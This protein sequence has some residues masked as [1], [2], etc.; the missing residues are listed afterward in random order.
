[1]TGLGLYAL[2]KIN[3]DDLI[4]YSLNP[5]TAKFPAKVTEFYTLA[6]R[7]GNKDI[8]YLKQNFGLNP[9]LSDPAIPKEKAI[10]YIT[11]FIDKGFDINTLSN[12][13]GL[14]ILHCAIMDNDSEVVLFL[15]VK[16]ADAG[17]K[18][19]Y[20][21]IEGKDEK[22]TLFG[23]NSMEL[24]KHLSKKDQKDRTNII[25]MLNELNIRFMQIP[26]GRNHIRHFILKQKDN[27]WLS[28]EV[29]SFSTL[30]RVFLTWPEKNPDDPLRKRCG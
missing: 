14:T 4:R 28:E 12:S 17:I 15:L 30:N 27:T 1:M 23:M 5:E 11:F 26:S 24:A 22:T 13:S 25:L 29:A 9:L 2:S 19:G 16:G 3:I 7:G 20:R 21:H 8:E 6:F 10:K 18:I